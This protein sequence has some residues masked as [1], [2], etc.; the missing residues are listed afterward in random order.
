M[1]FFSTPNI[2]TFVSFCDL[3]PSFSASSAGLEPT[4]PVFSTYTISG[5]VVGKEVGEGTVTIMAE[6]RALTSYCVFPDRSFLTL[7]DL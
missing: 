2:H 1:T 6:G 7:D 3:G 4:D 5:V